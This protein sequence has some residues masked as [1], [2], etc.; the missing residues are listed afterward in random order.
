M[1]PVGV[2]RLV[3]SV[4]LPVAEFRDPEGAREAEG[5]SEAVGASCETYPQSHGYARSSQS[6]KRSYVIPAMDVVNYAKSYL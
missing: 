2:S 3:I 1:T 4:P 6:R 5:A